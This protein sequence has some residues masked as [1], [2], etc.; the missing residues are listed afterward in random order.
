MG[1][2]T[3]PF[4]QRL[5]AERDEYQQRL[6]DLTAFID[7]TPE[8]RALPLD[9]R[10]LMVRQKS[11]LAFLVEICTERINRLAVSN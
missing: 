5:I 10:L 9:D 1:N 2:E 3:E 7:G 8:W 6:K 4:Y 11:A